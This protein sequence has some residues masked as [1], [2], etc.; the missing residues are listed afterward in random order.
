[1]YYIINIS[2]FVCIYRWQNTA[3]N[4]KLWRQKLQVLILLVLR[5]F[6]LFWLTV[7]I[8]LHLGR[9]NSKECKGRV[10]RE[11]KQLSKIRILQ[12]SW[13]SIL[14]EYLV[15]K[16]LLYI[17]FNGWH[18]KKLNSFSMLFLIFH[19]N[20]FQNNNREAMGVHVSWV[21]ILLMAGNHSTGT[22][23]HLFKFFM[24]LCR[25]KGGQKTA[26]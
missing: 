15:Q 25:V 14:A 2:W 4:T 5:F 3:S 20:C 22:L 12:G 10:P 9:S 21:C 13:R 19:M 1:M 11:R 23:K 16:V 24:F 8:N 26:V 17:N 18:M 7:L 6:Y